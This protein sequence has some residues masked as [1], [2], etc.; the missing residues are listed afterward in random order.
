MDM[1]GLAG[2]A[3]QEELE[4]VQEKRET[5]SGLNIPGFQ[6]GLVNSS[7][8]FDIGEYGNHA[9]AILSDGEIY[10]WG[11]GES[12]RLGRGNQTDSTVPVPVDDQWISGLNAVSLSLGGWLKN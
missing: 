2:L 10:C 12:N 9:C 11:E 7:V 6:K 8:T 4:E 5:L 3:A 1:S